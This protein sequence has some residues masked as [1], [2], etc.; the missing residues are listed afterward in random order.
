MSTSSSQMRSA[1]LATAALAA[2]MATAVMLNRPS[3]PSTPVELASGTFL[4]Q[5]RQ[6]PEFALKDDAGAV[7][8]NASLTGKWS[9]IFVGFTHCPDICPN[10]LG[11]L[12][13]VHRKLQE[14]GKFLQVVFLSVDPERDRPELLAAYV[15]YFDP[16]FIGVTGESAD[17]ESLGQSIGYVFMKSPGPSQ[18][19]YTMDHSASLIVIN[20][21]G[22][23]AAYLTPPL[24][25]DELVPDF[26]KIIPSQDA[27]S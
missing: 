3:A 17:L 25:L 15:D 18:E 4:P 9:V 1:L 10:T 16:S 21:Q 11:L 2:G 13:T 26:S 20:P 19:S 6:V 23:V 5:P 12:K 27:A 22:Q 7:F 24:K 8:N 14:Q